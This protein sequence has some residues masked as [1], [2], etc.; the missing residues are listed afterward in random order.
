MT[1]YALVADGQ[2]LDSGYPPPCARNASGAWVCPVDGVWTDELAATCGW[3]PVTETTAPVETASTYYLPGVALVGGVPT[4]SWTAVAKS[5]ERVNKETIQSQA[6][7]A[8]ATNTTFLALASPTNAQ[9][10]A[11]VKALTRQSQ[12]LI[13]LALNR[14]EAAE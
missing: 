8:L 1:T 6:A 4:R 2:I 12:G 7:T 11:Q 14:L 3:L 9:L 5:A 13:R 10:A